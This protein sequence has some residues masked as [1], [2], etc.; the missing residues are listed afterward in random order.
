M[1]KPTVKDAMTQRIEQRL[2]G[3]YLPNHPQASIGV[4]R[5]NSA[6]IRVRIIDPDFAGKDIVEREA[7]VLPIIRDMSDRVQDQITMLL[8][9]T[10]EEGKRSLLSAEFDDPRPST[11]W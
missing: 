6:S 4:Y 1:G 8:L 5:Y 7:E 2:G 3:E 10:P 9:I 11:L